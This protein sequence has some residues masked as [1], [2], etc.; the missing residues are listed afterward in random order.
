MVINLGEMDKSLEKHKIPQL[1]REEIDNKKCGALQL[2][3]KQHFSLK[4]FPQR[5]L[6]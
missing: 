4:T 1:T 5:R 6:K 2:A 3:K